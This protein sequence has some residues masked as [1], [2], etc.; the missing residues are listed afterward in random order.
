MSR[1]EISDMLGVGGVRRTQWS[2][3]DKE[4]RR[5]WLQEREEGGAGKSRTFEVGASGICP[6]QK[7]AGRA[8]EGE[9]IR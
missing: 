4:D 2:Q 1:E 3:Q 6:R 8:G 7:L 9:G 5:S